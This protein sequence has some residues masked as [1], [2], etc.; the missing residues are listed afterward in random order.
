MV[1][2][3]KL[4]RLPY[5]LYDPSESTEPDKY[6]AEVPSFPN[7]V[8]WSDTAEETLAILESVVMGMIQTYRERGYELPP[9]VSVL[10]TEVE[11]CS[12]SRV[13]E[14]DLVELIEETV[15]DE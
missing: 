3:R 2:S 1:A 4:Y 7:C 5:A 9:G 12:E 6:M 14:G 13:L 11:W 10:G 15:G 8:A